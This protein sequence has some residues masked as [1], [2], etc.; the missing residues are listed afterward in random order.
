MFGIQPSSCQVME[1]RSESFRCKGLKEEIKLRLDMT[2]SSAGRR[3]VL[4][5]C[6]VALTDLNV[7]Q[8]LR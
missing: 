2:M 6:K 3:K 1:S 8:V 5:G 7:M 4:R